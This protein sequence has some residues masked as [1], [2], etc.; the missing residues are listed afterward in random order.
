VYQYTIGLQNGTISFP[1]TAAASG[2]YPALA[3][4]ELFAVQAS[5]RACGLSG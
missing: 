3:Q 4:A 2:K 1:D 5:Q